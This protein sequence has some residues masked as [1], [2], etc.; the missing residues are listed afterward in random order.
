MSVPTGAMG[1]TWLAHC[2]DF[3]ARFSEIVVFGDCEHGKITLADELSKRLKMPVRVVQAEDYL[4]E[5]DANDLYQRYGGEAVAAA[6]K[7]ARLRPVSRIKELCDVRTVDLNSLERISTG[8]RE[9]DRVIGGFFFGKLILL[10]GRRGEGKSTFMG[11]LLVEALDQG[12]KVLAYSGELQDFHFKRWIDFQA[13]G[14]DYVICRKNQFGD[15]IYSLPEHV[16]GQIGRWYRGRAFLYD[17]AAAGEDTEGILATIEQAVCRYGI[18]FVCI[19]NLMTALEINPKEDFYR[20]QSRFVRELKSMAVRLDAAVLLVAHP[21]KS[22]SGLDNDD[23]MG[24]SDIT[25]LADVVL[26][27]RRSAEADCDSRLAVLK[28]RMDGRLPP[29]EQEIKLYYSR[30][31]KRITSFETGQRVYG[32]EKGGDRAVR[33]VESGALDLPF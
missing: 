14:P 13:A 5:K 19:D 8:I 15:E 24:S 25:N 22:G 6:V 31:T 32:W 33:L 7:N 11:Q 16:V 23:V 12:Y 3:V 26:S 10:T 9:L 20:A 21:K 28:N 2:W 29:R 17:N 27:Y 1:F 18:K 30:S 4:G